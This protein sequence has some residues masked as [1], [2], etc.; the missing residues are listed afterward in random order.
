MYGAVCSQ[1]TRMYL[2][3][4]LSY[5]TV[6]C[7]W[8]RARNC[9]YG[10]TDNN[11]LVKEADAYL[12]TQVNCWAVSADFGG[13]QMQPE[14]GYTFVIPEGAVIAEKGDPVVNSR[15]SIALNG[16][17]G[18][19]HISIGNMDCDA[20]IYDLFGRKVNVPQRGTIYI[21]SGKRFWLNKYFYL[22]VFRLHYCCCDHPQ[23]Q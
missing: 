13:F 19:D 20:P 7:L 15:H 21:Q 16:S 10:E 6:P 1:T 17:S 23:Q 11:T 22:S 4:L 12:D 9:N 5:T 3:L 14:V 8:P 2:T 18:I